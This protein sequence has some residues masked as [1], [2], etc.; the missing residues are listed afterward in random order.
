VSEI[1]VRW[2]SDHFSSEIPFRKMEE[3]LMKKELENKVE[4]IEKGVLKIQK[5]I[6]EF[7]DG[8]LTRKQADDLIGGF[9]DLIIRLDELMAEVK[10]VEKR[11]H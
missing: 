10:R 8:N 1:T 11:G 9:D 4:K 3:L 5:M 2:H 7:S 6:F